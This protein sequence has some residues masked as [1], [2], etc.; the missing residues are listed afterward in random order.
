[1][2]TKVTQIVTPAHRDLWSC[3]HRPPNEPW[4]HTEN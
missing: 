2:L 4:S 1:M 3:V